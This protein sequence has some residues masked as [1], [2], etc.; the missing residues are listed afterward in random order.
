MTSIT[1]PAPTHFVASAEEVGNDLAARGFSP[2][3]IAAIVAWKPYCSPEGCVCEK[4]A[5]CYY[6]EA[7]TGET[8]EA[9]AAYAD[10]C[11]E[12][13]EMLRPFGEFL[14]GTPD[15]DDYHEKW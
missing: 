6:C 2:A 12:Q 7:C 11:A 10:Y 4:Y 5:D 8:A 1:S 9:E 14:Y 13:D 3:E 15:E